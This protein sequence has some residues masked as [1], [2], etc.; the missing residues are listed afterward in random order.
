MSD[1][2]WGSQFYASFRVGHPI[3]TRDEVAAGVGVKLE[4]GVS[5]GQPRTRGPRY[6]PHP[7]GGFEK[8]SY[9]H[10]D[11]GKGEGRD[12]ER[13]LDAY[14]DGLTERRPFFEALAA[15]GGYAD[16]FVS[17]FLAESTNGVV[18]EPAL[19]RKLA[20]LGIKLGISLYNYDPQRPA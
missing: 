16:F 9:C 18:I 13:T 17:L 20:D 12:L 1:D 5:V 19:S 4:W 3:W 14:A 15:S 2:R 10:F 8:R 7:Q 11:V 6:V